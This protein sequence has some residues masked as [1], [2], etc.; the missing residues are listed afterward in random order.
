MKSTVLHQLL[1]MLKPL[2]PLWTRA[3][4]PQALLLTN[5][6]VGLAEVQMDYFHCFPA[7]PV[8]FP[9]VFRP[10]ATTSSFYAT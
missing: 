8:Y 2:V 1:E 6:D 9:T 7:T 4:Q 5:G 10:S 3:A